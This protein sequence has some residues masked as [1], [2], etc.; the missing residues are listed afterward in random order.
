MDLGLDSRRDL[1][2]VV[3]WGRRDARVAD[4]LVWDGLRRSA[5]DE[6]RQVVVDVEHLALER[7]V[8]L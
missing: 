1:E 2:A 5:T 7:I 8:R 3:A 4:V 6:R